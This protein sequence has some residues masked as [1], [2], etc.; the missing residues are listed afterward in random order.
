M[1]F[2]WEQLMIIPSDPIIVQL[3]EDV[4]VWERQLVSPHKSPKSTPTTW[5]EWTQAKFQDCPFLTSQKLI[6][7]YCLVHYF[8]LH[9]PVMC[10]KITMMWLFYV[11]RKFYSIP[12]PHAQAEGRKG[13]GESLMWI[14][15]LNAGWIAPG[16]DQKTWEA[17]ATKFQG[18]STAHIQAGFHKA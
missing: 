17:S 14:R 6:P 7:L 3:S 18:L 4:C 10:T 1:E 13:W 12:A 15:T 5:T 16:E 8:P 2:P 11:Q 9:T